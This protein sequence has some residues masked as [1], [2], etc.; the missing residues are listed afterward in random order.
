MLGRVLLRSETVGPWIT[1]CL[2]SKL[3]M[4]AVVD[5]L[6]QVSTVDAGMGRL[7][8]EFA[9]LPNLL[10]A[11][12]QLPPAVQERAVQVMRRKEKKALTTLF[13]PQ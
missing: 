1:D 11:M 7:T 4:G 12:L 10:P 9:A 5:Y 6:A 8:H 13:N 2:Y 3:R